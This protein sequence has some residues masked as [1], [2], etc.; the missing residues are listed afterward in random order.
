[1]AVDDK[2][3]EIVGCCKLFEKESGQ[4]WMSHLAVANSRQHQGIG[5]QLMNYMEQ[6][7]RT[8]NYKKIGCLARLT[9]TK[10]FEKAGYKISGLP[11]HYFGTTQVVWMEK[12]L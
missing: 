6:L 5:K 3:N 1:M 7:A 2:T 8:Q 4:A 11:S 10:F 12:D 9:T